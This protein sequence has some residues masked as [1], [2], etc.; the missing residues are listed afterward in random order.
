MYY[1]CTNGVDEKQPLIH[2]W[3]VTFRNSKSSIV[4]TLTHRG[5]GLVSVDHQNSSRYIKNMCIFLDEWVETDSCEGWIHLAKIGIRL[6]KTLERAFLVT[7]II[8]RTY[9]SFA[10]DVFWFQRMKDEIHYY[11]TFQLKILALAPI[12]FKH[13]EQLYCFLIDA[14]AFNWNGEKFSST[15]MHH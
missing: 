13:T 4:F 1:W 7:G 10:F 8:M 14:N 9:L 12:T 15:D 11:V 6:I 2:E 5:W 3:V